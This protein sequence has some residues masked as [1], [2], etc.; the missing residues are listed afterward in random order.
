MKTIKEVI[1]NLDNALNP[2][3]N[4]YRSPISADEL[5]EIVKAQA[6]LIKQ[7]QSDIAELDRRTSLS[8]T[9]KNIKLNNS[10]GIKNV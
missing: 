9:D 6:E 4:T 7:L 5:A 2:P 1:D 10:W 3:P 8:D